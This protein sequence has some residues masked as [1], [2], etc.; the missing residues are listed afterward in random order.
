[1]RHKTAQK[2]KLVKCLMSRGNKEKKEIYDYVFDYCGA[3][4]GS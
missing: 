1:M 3:A 2:I 4:I